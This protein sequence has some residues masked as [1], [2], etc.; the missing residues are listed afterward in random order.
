MGLWLS[1]R[2]DM[3]SA[4]TAIGAGFAPPAGT[5]RQPPRSA[6]ANGPYNAPVFVGPHSVMRPQAIY[7]GATHMGWTDISITVAKRDAHCRSHRND[8]CQRRHLY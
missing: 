6:G 8:G 3:E 2:A 5:L 1:S 7:K 4:P